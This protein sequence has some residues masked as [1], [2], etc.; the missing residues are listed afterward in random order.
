MVAPAIPLPAW[1]LQLHSITSGP[2]I[3]PYDLLVA[4]SYGGLSVLSFLT[5]NNFL[6]HAGHGGKAT[7]CLIPP[8]SRPNPKSVLNLS[9]L[10]YGLL[11]KMVLWLILLDG[12]V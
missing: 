11:T 2:V 3:V 9:L 4:R 5:S 8:G 10:V 12:S 6:L 7:D 1:Q